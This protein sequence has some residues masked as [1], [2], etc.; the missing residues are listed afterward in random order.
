MQRLRRETLLQSS[1][2]RVALPFACPCSRRPS[3]GGAAAGCSNR[4]WA[5]KWNNRLSLRW[6]PS[7]GRLL[8]R[9]LRGTCCTRTP[10][11]RSMMKQWKPSEAQQGMGGLGGGASCH[12]C[13][14]ASRLRWAFERVEAGDGA[15]KP[16][17][18]FRPFM[19]GVELGL[20]VFDLVLRFV[21]TCGSRSTSCNFL[22]TKFKSGVSVK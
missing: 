12:H 7:F 20:R 18:R 13:S 11:S 3:P 2:G 14:C 8:L 19:I 17:S 9:D 5:R 16:Q 6:S 22:L 1:K 21:F 10:P 15:Q 4:K